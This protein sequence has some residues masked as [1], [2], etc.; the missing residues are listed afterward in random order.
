LAGITAVSLEQKR[1]TIRDIDDDFYKL[2]SGVTDFYHVD[3][4]PARLAKLSTQLG[5][6]STE[7]KL[8]II[9]FASACTYATVLAFLQDLRKEAHSLVW[10]QVLDSVSQV[11]IR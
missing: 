7:D 10:S 11:S 2:I 1:D 9:T 8:A 4:S 5:R 3:Y 6:L